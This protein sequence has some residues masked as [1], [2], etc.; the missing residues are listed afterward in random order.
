[1]SAHEIE[2]TWLD[3]T[4]EVIWTEY[5]TIQDGILVIETNRYTREYRHIPLASIREWRT[6]A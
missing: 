3:G 2:V 4:K 1:M 6:K 5:H